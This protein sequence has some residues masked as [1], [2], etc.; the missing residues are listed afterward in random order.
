MG[1]GEINGHN[2]FDQVITHANLQLAWRK[3]SRGKSRKKDV[4]EFSKRL[5]YNLLKLHYLLLS[6][7]YRHSGY[8]SFFVAD[9]KLRHIHKAAV[10]DR[11]VHQ[12]IVQIIEPLFDP[13]FIFDSYSSRSGKGTHRA[14][15]KLRQSARK[16][17]RNNTRDVWFLKCDIR[18]FFDSISHGILLSLL[19]RKI[20]DRRLLDL[21]ENII[22]SFHVMPEI[23]IP[24]GNLTSQLFSNIYLNELDQF[25]K[26]RLSI[27]HYIR[28]ADDFIIVGTDRAYLETL[29]NIFHDYLSRS[30]E[31][32]LHPRKIALRPWHQ[33]IDYLG[34]VIFPHHTILRRK[35]GKRM[36]RRI[37]RKVLAGA[38]ADELG[39]TAQSY[40]GILSHCRG[41]G[42][43]KRTAQAVFPS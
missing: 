12:A 5:E 3:F 27:K 23:G 4:R 28:Y 13:G 6:G 25:A 2:L 40:L 7:G 17:S 21:L 16:L 29:I 39:A 15:A 26:R 22:G 14:V 37:N 18:K 31:L 11:V 42:W 34:Y 38:S 1:G 8:V 35:T 33:G 41:F 24:L 43:Q 19:S 20:C 36:I 9:P 30:L 32:D 10:V